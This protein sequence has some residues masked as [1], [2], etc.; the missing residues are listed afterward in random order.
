VA[1]GIAE[2]QTFIDGNKRLALIAM[3]TFLEVNDVALEAPDREL[4]AWIINLNSGPTP[5]AL[6]GLIRPRL[7]AIGQSTSAN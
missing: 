4:A 3:L 5:E 7:R 2:S 1:H 6:A